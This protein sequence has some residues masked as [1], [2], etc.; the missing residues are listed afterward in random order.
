MEEGR[1]VVIDIIK[2]PSVVSVIDYFNKTFKFDKF[3]EYTNI[4]LTND[5]F[6]DFALINSKSNEELKYTSGVT[7]IP[8]NNYDKMTVLISDCKFT[9]YI[10]AHELCHVYDILCF[11]QY[12]CNGN[13]SKCDPQVILSLHISV[14]HSF[15][16]QSSSICVNLFL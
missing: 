11:S 9:Q 12:Y 5:I 15:L 3:S 6:N 1:F 8:N 13:I 7:I 16:N 14:L 10:I 2:H 4:F